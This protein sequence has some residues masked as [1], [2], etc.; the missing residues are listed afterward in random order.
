ME[1]FKIPS[2]SDKQFNWEI[3]EARPDPPR[4]KL[5]YKFFGENKVLD[6]RGQV[7]QYY[8]SNSGLVQY[9]FL[10]LTYAEGGNKITR[11]SI[12]TSKTIRDKWKT[13]D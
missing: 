9:L 1:N 13:M 2:I 11:N 3:R 7:W 6:E 5:I 8:Y 12:L 10:Y 4:G